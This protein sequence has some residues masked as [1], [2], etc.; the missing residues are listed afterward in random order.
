MLRRLL[1]LATVAPASAL[2]LTPQPDCLW[3][4]TSQQFT[5]DVD[6]LPAWVNLRQSSFAETTVYDDAQHTW[7]LLHHCSTGHYLLFGVGP[8]DERRVHDRYAA[9]LDMSAKVTLREIGQDLADLGAGVR[10]GKG[11]VGRCDCNHLEAT[12]ALN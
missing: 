4:S 7:T 11:D 6:A 1:F 2:A 10:I 3:D 5:E 12:G 9:L 8:Q